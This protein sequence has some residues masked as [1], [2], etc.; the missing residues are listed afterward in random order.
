MILYTTGKHEIEIKHCSIRLGSMTQHGRPPCILAT[1]GGLGL[2][3]WC[4]L[5]QGYRDC[6]H[7]QFAK[8][9]HHAWH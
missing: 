5:C 4:H 8:R 3:P 9:N 7:C 1:T 6:A 2:H